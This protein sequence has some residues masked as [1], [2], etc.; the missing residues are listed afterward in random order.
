[1]GGSGDA[2]TLVI[3]DGQIVLGV[4]PGTLVGSGTWRAL[5]TGL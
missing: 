5:W 1:M 3:D 4:P 2:G